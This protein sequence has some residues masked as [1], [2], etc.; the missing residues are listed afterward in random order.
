MCEEDDVAKLVA[1]WLPNTLVNKVICATKMA[2]L[3]LL[4]IRCRMMF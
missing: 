3:L 2:L 1:D 4:L